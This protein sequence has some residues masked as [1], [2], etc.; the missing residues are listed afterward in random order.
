MK[1]VLFSELQ[2]FSKYVVGIPFTASGMD[3]A[4][5]RFLAKELCVPFLKI[6][7]GDSNNL[8]MFEALADGDL[9]PADIPV[10]VSTGMSH[11]DQ[12]RTIYNQVPKACT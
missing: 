4:S 5:L 3:E 1:N 10:V 12:V 2:K 6:G 11:M 7:S 8:P 9:V